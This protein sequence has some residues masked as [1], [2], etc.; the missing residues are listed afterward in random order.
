ALAQRVVVIGRGRVLADD[1]L[2]AVVGRVGVRRVTVTLPDGDVGS[3]QDLP[4]VVG[5]EQDETDRS[6]YRLLTADADELVRELVRVGSRFS[7][8]EVRSASL[9]E[10][11][12]TLTSDAPAGLA[13]DSAHAPTTPEEV[14]A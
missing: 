11:F 6:R 4:G 13:A 3:I 14:T 1:T 2:R 8:L 12:L 5:V 10:A 9:E 7:G